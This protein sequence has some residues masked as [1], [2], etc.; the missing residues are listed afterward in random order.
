M[1]ETHDVTT[2]MGC[3]WDHLP[4]LT[5]DE[6]EEFDLI[7]YTGKNN[8]G[9]KTNFQTFLNSLGKG[10]FQVKQTKWDDGSFEERFTIVRVT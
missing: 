7:G 5:K 3:A 4:C 9:E 10:E 1:I 8:A 2:H 6:Q